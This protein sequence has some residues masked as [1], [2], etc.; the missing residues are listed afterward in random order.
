MVS[1]TCYRV[2]LDNPRHTMDIVI[3]DITPTRRRS[4]ISGVGKV[5]I[6]VD[7]QDRAKAFWTE[8]LAF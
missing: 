5:V 8:K 6:D 1:S 7:D 4:M 2:V 3:V